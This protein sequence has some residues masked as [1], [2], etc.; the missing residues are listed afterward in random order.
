MDYANQTEPPR[1]E[2][3]PTDITVG[4]E[5]WRVQLRP[6]RVKDVPLLQRVETPEE[7]QR[8]S[9]FLTALRRLPAELVSDDEPEKEDKPKPVTQA[10]ANLLSLARQAKLLEEQQKAEEA[11]KTDQRRRWQAAIRAIDARVS[12]EYATRIRHTEAAG[13][14]QRQ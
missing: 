10:E 14:L 4:D 2:L 9:A 12:G 8:F 3:I 6:E 13:Y 5:V 11:A 7:A 1:P